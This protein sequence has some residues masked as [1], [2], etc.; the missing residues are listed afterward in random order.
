[1]RNPFNS[2]N[3]IS[4]KQDSSSSSNEEWPELVDTTAMIG[5][6]QKI[7]TQPPAPREPKREIDLTQINTDDLKTIEKQD[8]FMYFS[9]PEV[10]DA[11]LQMREIDIAKLRDATI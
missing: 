3:N 5:I 1:M 7:K 2:P 11:K 8:P 10:R 6:R 4:I 9:I